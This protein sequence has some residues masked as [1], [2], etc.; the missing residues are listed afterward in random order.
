MERITKQFQE[1]MSRVSLM[2][3]IFAAIGLFS[4]MAGKI[5][6]TATWHDVLGP[7]PVFFGLLG[8]LNAFVAQVQKPKETW[9]GVDRRQ[10]DA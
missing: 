10:G 7:V 1:M 6:D 2:T 5:T 4:A 9:D 3:W 8:F